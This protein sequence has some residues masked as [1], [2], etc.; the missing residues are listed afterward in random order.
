ME[1]NVP[2][3]QQDVTEFRCKDNEHGGIPAAESFPDKADRCDGETA[4]RCP[5]E[6]VGQQNVSDIREMYACVKYLHHHHGRCA[7]L[8]INTIIISRIRVI[9]VVIRIT[10]TC[11]AAILFAN[12]GPNGNWQLATGDWTNGVNNE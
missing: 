1:K 8:A 4:D 11:K 9:L 2:A 5:A 12:A 3:R 6:L 7:Y 10:T